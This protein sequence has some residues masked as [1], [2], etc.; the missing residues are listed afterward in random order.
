MLVLPEAMLE[1]WRGSDVYRLLATL[2]G[3]VYREK[4]GRKTF[5]FPFQGKHYY[6]KLHLGIGW[7]K[8][9]GRLIRFRWPVTGARNEWQAIQR[10]EALGV[11]TMRLV[12]YGQEGW[13]PARLKSFVITEELAGT[14]SLEDYC[15]RWQTRPP[16][17]R[18]K[19]NLI[20]EVARIARTLHENGM[21][22]RDF[23]IC[24][25]LLDI[26]SSEETADPDRLRLFL[27]DLHRVQI[28]RHTPK[29]W[30][31]KDVAALYFSSMDI[32]LTRRDLLRFV[33]QYESQPLKK[34]LSRHGAFWRRVEKRGQSFHR[35]YIRKERHRPKTEPSA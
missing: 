9:L 13:N 18:L 25:F 23:Y 1:K 3:R 32:G 19:K 22:H 17:H 2:D 27:I 30:R 4:D 16:T 6:A 10:L 21:N 11:K 34:A 24:H 7:K 29:R 15:R 20:G 28:R 26:G 33:R 8:F 5:R 31:I 35:E 12:G 14:K